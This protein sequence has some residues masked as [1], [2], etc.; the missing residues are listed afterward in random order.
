MEQ[1][2]N[3]HH[4]HHTHLNYKQQNQSQELPES[5]IVKILGYIVD[6]DAPTKTSDG[7]YHGDG[8]CS[9]YQ[10]GWIECKEAIIQALTSDMDELIESRKSVISDL[11][12]DLEKAVAA[13]KG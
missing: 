6:L 2:Q 8:F 1:V 11:F 4:T 7:S 13:H 10:V 3:T 12:V 9:G 5:V